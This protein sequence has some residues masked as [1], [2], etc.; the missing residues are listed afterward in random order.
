MNLKFST[1][2]LQT[3]PW[4]SDII[5]IILVNK[6][7]QFINPTLIIFSTYLLLFPYIK[8]TKRKY[9]INFLYVS[10]SLSLIWAIIAQDY[11]KYQHQTFLIFQ[12][13]PYSFFLWA[14]CLFAIYLLYEH[15]SHKFKSF[16]SKILVFSSIYWFLLIIIETAYYHF[17]NIRDLATSNYPGLPLC[18]CIH[19]PLWMQIS[20]LCMG[21]TYFLVCKLVELKFPSKKTIRF[22]NNFLNTY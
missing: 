2:F 11:Y 3:K 17:L 15:I 9:L 10:T 20:Y 4:V 22:S 19:G 14:V 1:N 7:L 12:L 6:L 21:P 18:N 13:N 16:F 5:L 8:F